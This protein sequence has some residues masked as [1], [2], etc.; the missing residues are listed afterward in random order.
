VQASGHGGVFRSGDVSELREQIAR[1]LDTGPLPRSK[2]EALAAWARCIGGDAGATYLREVFDASHERK[3]YPPP[4]WDAN[5]PS[6]VTDATRCLD[7][8]VTKTVFRSLN[9]M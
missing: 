2:R 8:L 1:A 5:R 9:R 3:A 7:V 4:P 6:P